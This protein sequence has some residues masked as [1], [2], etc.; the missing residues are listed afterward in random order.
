MT[1]ATALSET[2]RPDTTVAAFLADRPLRG[3]SGS[4]TVASA[5]H[6]M[7]DDGIG[8]LVVVEARRLVGI[9]TERDVAVRVIAGHRDPHL[10]LVREV[11]TRDPRTIAAEAS[12]ADAHALM[13]V[14]GFRHLPVMRGGEVVGMISLRDIPPGTAQAPGAPTGALTDP[15]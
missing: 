2:I 15:A 8:A 10:T 7:R 13:R 14:G 1:D 6:R 3:V 11:M 12:L 5:C 4:F 9:V